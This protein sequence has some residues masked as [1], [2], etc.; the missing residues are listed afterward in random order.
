MLRI[1]DLGRRLFEGKDTES[2]DQHAAIG[3][4]KTG[5]IFMMEHSDFAIELNA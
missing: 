1:E 4:T 5:S 2:T 3:R